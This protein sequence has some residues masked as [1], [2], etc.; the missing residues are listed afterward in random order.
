ML[1]RQM[2]YG[3]FL[4]KAAAAYP[5]GLNKALATELVDL[6]R[7][8]VAVPTPPIPDSRA[9]ASTQKAPAVDRLL[10]EPGHIRAFRA[11]V[12]NKHTVTTGSWRNTLVSTL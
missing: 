4:T 1:R 7:A 2:P 10:A 8:A 12:D 11:N 5:S 6:A 3:D 9:S